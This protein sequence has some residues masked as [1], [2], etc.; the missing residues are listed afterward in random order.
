MEA[1][2]PISKKKSYAKFNDSQHFLSKALEK[3]HRRRDGLSKNGVVMNWVMNKEA[4]THCIFA[5]R[6]NHHL[7]ILRP[8][9]TRKPSQKT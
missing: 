9:A 8:G 5:S 4:W 3:K 1:Y 2:Q 7:K 6:Q